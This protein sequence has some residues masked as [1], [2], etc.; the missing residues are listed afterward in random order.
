MS[1]MDLGWQAAVAVDD[2]GIGNNHP[3]N[4]W[5]TAKYKSDHGFLLLG[6]SVELP[7]GF[8]QH[9]QLGL[10]QHRPNALLSMDPVVWADVTV[11]AQRD[12]QVLLVL[13]DVVRVARPSRVAHTA[14]QRLDAPNVLALARGE[15]VVHS[16]AG[17]LGSL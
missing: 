12:R 3:K 1:H 16:T 2:A 9:G 15:P 11:I 4:L 10:L 8:V 14:V 7:D 6:L 5:V 17:Y 13:L